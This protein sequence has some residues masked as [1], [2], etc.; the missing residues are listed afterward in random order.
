MQRELC[1]DGDTG[2]MRYAEETSKVA[3]TQPGSKERI[4]V[5][6][7]SNVPQTVGKSSAL[8]PALTD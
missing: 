3:A 8:I 4:R 7:S 2:I 5:A 6:V 1:W